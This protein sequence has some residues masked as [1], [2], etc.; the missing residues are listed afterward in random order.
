MSTCACA[1]AVREGDDVIIAD[2][3]G[4]Q[5]R[6]TSLRIVV[7]SKLP[8]H[9]QTRIVESNDGKTFTVSF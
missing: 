8:L 6:K 7:R 1:V 9:Q 2:M 5:Y 3:C 4:G